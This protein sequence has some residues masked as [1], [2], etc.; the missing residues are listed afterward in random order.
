MGGNMISYTHDL[1]TAHYES[2]YIKL[3]DFFEKYGGNCVVDSAFS[4]LRRPYLLKPS[5]SDV[6]SCDSHGMINIFEADG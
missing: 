5:R 2:F 3:E 6:T 4:L 1:T